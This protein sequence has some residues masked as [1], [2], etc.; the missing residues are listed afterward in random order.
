MVLSRHF[1]N[2][3]V[4][5]FFCPHAFSYISLPVS[6][7]LPKSYAFRVTPS[8]PKVRTSQACPHFLHAKRHMFLHCNLYVKLSLG[9]RGWVHVYASL[10]VLFSL[11]TLSRLTPGCSDSWAS[12]ELGSAFWPHHRLL[13]TL[14]AFAPSWRVASLLQL[15]DALQEWTYWSLWPC[16]GESRTSRLL[17]G[18]L[19]AWKLLSCS[20]ILSLWSCCSLW[21]SVSQLFLLSHAWCI[22][23]TCF[24]STERKKPLIL[25]CSEYTGFTHQ[26][27][28]RE[29]KILLLPL[30]TCS[31][32][33]MQFS[34]SSF[35]NAV[36]GPSRFFLS[37]FY[38]F[39]ELLGGFLALGAKGQ[40]Y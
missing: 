2:C 24:L 1:W 15:I 17:T 7:F 40:K 9:P 33:E 22:L 21:R 34:V 23:E 18:V 11:S 6:M 16:V 26:D 20:L 32:W 4:A 35:M 19:S 38:L 14:S 13:G 29:L 37:G 27:N 12:W 10:C 25:M 8:T 5:F 28:A 36:G 39:C 3:K 30:S 31:L